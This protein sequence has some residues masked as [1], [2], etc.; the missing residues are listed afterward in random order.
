MQFISASP[1]GAFIMRALTHANLHR[2]RPLPPS[3]GLGKW[4]KHDGTPSPSPAPLAFVVDLLSSHG[5][6]EE[7]ED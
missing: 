3:P 1:P 2:P 7:T 6:N 5:D 4:T